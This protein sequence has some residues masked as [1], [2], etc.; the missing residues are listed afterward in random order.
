MI[1]TPALRTPRPA[2]TLKA[3]AGN[4]ENQEMLN[5]YINI[6][7]LAAYTILW[8]GKQLKPAEIKAGLQAIHSCLLNT[9]DL[10]T[11]FSELVQRLVIGRQNLPSD[12]GRLRTLPSEWFSPQYK[13]GFT[14]TKSAYACLEKK[15]VMRPLHGLGL[16]FI[17]DAFVELYDNHSAKEYH[18]W[19]SWF[20]SRNKNGLLNILLAF[21]ANRWTQ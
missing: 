14:A 9:A 8:N 20:Q 19:R 6:A 21:I 18:Y 16:K 15:R 7:W 4:K 5:H 11:G 12:Y 1:T 10:H 13:Y 17:V 2:Y 3:I